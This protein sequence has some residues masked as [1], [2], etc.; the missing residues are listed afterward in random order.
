MSTLAEKRKEAIKLHEKKVDTILRELG[1]IQGAMSTLGLTIGADKLSQVM[2][3]LRHDV[4]TLKT[5][6]SVN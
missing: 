6:A 2:S 4:L 1:E 5:S 3:S